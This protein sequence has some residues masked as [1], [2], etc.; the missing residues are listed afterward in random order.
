MAIEIPNSFVAA[1]VLKGTATIGV[2][3][4]EGFDVST[5]VRVSAG[6]YGIELTEEVNEDHVHASISAVDAGGANL[7]ASAFVTTDHK[8][9]VVKTADAAGVATDALRMSVG[10]QL[11]KS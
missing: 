11:F 4:S 1:A 9:L 6:L 8:T 3:G 5:F 7:I 10:V 2:L